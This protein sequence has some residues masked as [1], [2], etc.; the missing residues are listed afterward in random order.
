MLDNEENSAIFSV[1][2]AIGAR[3]FFRV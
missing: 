2:A 1:G 3:S